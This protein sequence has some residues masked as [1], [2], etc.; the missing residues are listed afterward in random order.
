M[1][2]HVDDLFSEGL[3]R[4]LQDHCTSRVVRDIEA[5][6]SVQRLWGQIEESGFADVML[7]ESAG[8]AGLGLAGIFPLMELC[9]TFAVPLPL[10]ETML[11]RALLAEAGA[12]RPPGSICLTEAAIASDGSLACAAIPCGRV[13]DWVLVHCATEN[14]LLAVAAARQSPAIFPLDADLQWDAPAVA[15]ACRIRGAIDVRTLSAC[16]YAAQLAGALMSVFS[17]TLQYANDRRQF[18]RPIG[19]FQAVQHQLSVISEHAFAARMAAQIGCRGDGI[20]PNRLA[21]AVAK[22]RTSEAALE[23][24]SLAHSIHGAIG[25]TEEYD[26]Q[27]FTRR[28]HAW[29]Q[30]CGS[31]SY[32]HTVLGS[33]LI[34]HHSGPA[35]DLARAV[36]D[37]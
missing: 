26:L 27:L 34:D 11:A 21:V 17:R 8:G 16:I 32:W 14:L 3:S 5:G 19:K 7:E 29:R 12:D 18:G 31:E 28:L 23:T 22:A 33:A 36:T 13:A 1:T 2:H 35:V 30:A 15:S 10:A 20:T 9:G 25:F 24:A 6:G 37:I 4:L